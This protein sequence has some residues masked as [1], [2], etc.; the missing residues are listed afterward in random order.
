MLR[1]K[2]CMYRMSLRN[3]QAGNKKY[4]KRTE[5]N[6]DKYKLNVDVAIILRCIGINR[7]DDGKSNHST[8]VFIINESNNLPE[9]ENDS[10]NLLGKENKKEISNQICV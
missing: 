2:L 6:F 3:K 5:F 10:V 7:L 1:A 4:L 9:A 8:R